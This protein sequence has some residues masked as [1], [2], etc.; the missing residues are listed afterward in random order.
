L[1]EQQLVS[2]MYDLF[3]DISVLLT[4]PEICALLDGTADPKLLDMIVNLIKKRHEML[5][6]C[7]PTKDKV[8]DLLAVLSSMLDMDVCMTLAEQ[9]KSI[10]PDGEY[11]GFCPPEFKEALAW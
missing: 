1:T 3:D 10:E 2:A 7:L 6:G 9:H 8:E 5:T 4:A 11:D